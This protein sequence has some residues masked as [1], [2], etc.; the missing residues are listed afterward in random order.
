MDQGPIDAICQTRLGSTGKFLGDVGFGQIELLNDVTA[1]IF[2]RPRA[3]CGGFENR[4]QQRLEVRYGHESSSE[5][6]SREHR[7]RDDQFWCKC[8]VWR[9]QVL[10]TPERG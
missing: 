5:I 1:V 7:L 4:P 3:L 9:S 2:R 8:G 6:G 10:S